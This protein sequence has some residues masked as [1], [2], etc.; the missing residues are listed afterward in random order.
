MPPFPFAK[1][2]SKD[3]YLWGLAEVYPSL[4]MGGTEASVCVCVCVCVCVWMNPIPFQEE[5]LRV[6]I[7]EI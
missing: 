3:K 7:L 2:D 1:E 6:W 4:P 5:K